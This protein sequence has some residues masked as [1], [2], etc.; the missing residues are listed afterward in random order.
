MSHATAGERGPV[1]RP[2][3][4][5]HGALPCAVE[6]L[7]CSPCRPQAWL[8][9]NM[10]E[11]AVNAPPQ[12]KTKLQLKTTKC[13]GCIPPENTNLCAVTAGSGAIDSVAAVARA[14]GATEAEVL[15]LSAAELME[16]MRDELHVPV[17]PRKRIAAEAEGRRGAL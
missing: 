1:I 3:N 9:F 14:A 5:N 7:P 6:M 13:P 16:L 2:T 4:Q 10:I 8:L 15:A 12:P 11:N 17:L